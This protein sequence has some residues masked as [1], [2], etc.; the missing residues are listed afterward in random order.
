M[1]IYVNKQ[2]TEKEFTDY[3]TKLLLAISRLEVGLQYGIDMTASIDSIVDDAKQ[4]LDE[5]T[6]LHVIK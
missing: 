4:L 1:K 2:M 3:R 5:A 6:Y